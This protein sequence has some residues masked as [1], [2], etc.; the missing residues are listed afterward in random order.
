MRMSTWGNHDLLMKAEFLFF[1]VP[2]FIV[3]SLAVPMF[4]MLY[5]SDEAIYASMTVKVI[6]RQWYWIYEIE[7]P[8]DEDE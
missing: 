8:V 3:W 4:T 1:W 2:T 7:S 5:M 6:G